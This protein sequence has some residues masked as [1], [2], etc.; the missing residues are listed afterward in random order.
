M[1]LESRL[2]EILTAF[3]FLCAIGYTVITGM[4]VGTEAVGIVAL[5]LTGGLSLIIGTYFRFVARRLED[6]PEDNEEAEVATARARSASSR[7][8]ATGRSP[9]RALPRWWA[10]RWPSSRSGCS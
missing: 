7:R 10:S 8:A 4:S 1:K 3:F 6:R 2:F 9:A 5:F